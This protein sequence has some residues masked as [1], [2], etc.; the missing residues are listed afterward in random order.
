MKSKALITYLLLSAL[1]LILITLNLTDRIGALRNFVSYV[2]YP[3]P[4]LAAKAVMETRKLGGNLSDIINVFEENKE[5]SH[6]IEQLKFYE[7]QYRFLQKENASL[8]AMLG[9]SR[10][11]H[12]RMVAASVVSRDPVNWYGTVIIDKGL[13]SGIMP[14]MAVVAVSGRSMGLVG[15][16]VETG[17]GFSKVMLISDPLS[18][19]PVKI[20]RNGETCV[21]AGL[22]RAQL[23]LDYLSPGSDIRLGD[24]VIT[25]G[26]GEI[27]PAGIPVGAVS[28]G[29]SQGKTYFFRAAVIPE[30]SPG[31][32]DKVLVIVK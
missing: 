28:G 20:L 3:T 24:G 31:E 2:L 32:I 22:G 9:L 11:E 8:K 21:A 18:Y 26:I 12:G 6:K 14:D 25:S 4:Y 30:V 23:L 13:S 15:R 10:Q 5:L 19:V 16:T 17:G 1:C 27:F 29:V 7:A